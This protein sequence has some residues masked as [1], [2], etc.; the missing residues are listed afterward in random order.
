MQSL[1]DAAIYEHEIEKFQLIETH[2]SWVLLTGRYAYK[3]KKPVDLGFVDFSSLDSRRFYCNEELRLNRRLAAQQYV[4]VVSITGTPQDPVLNGSSSAF[5]YAVKMVQFPQDAQLDRVLARGALKVS[6]IDELA[7]KIAAFHAH[8]ERASSAGPY[9]RPDSLQALVMA[10]FDRVLKEQPHDKQRILALR[11][12]A[13]NEFT[14][15]HDVLAAR[16][17]HGFIRECHGDLHLRN[18]AL[19]N[20]ELVLFDCIEFNEELRW[21]DV[22]SEVAFVVM[23]LDDRGQDALAHRFLNAYLEHTGDYA[24]LVLLPYYLTYRAMVRAMVEC[25]RAGQSELSQV[26]RQDLL[27]EQRGYLALAEHYTHPPS[28][29]LII[30]HGLSGSGKT[31]VTQALLKQEGGIRIRS[32]VE[33]KRLYGLAPDARTQSRFGERLYTADVTRQTYERLADLAQ[34]LLASGFTVIADAAFLKKRQRDCFG[35]LADTLG[36]PFVILDCQAS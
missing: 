15:Q 6:H 35:A 11:A 33:R 20:D 13:Q 10:N 3:I 24:G 16:K 28:P 14:K 5:E 2:I 21:I 32:D 23:D 4:D 8:I 7:A 36:V 17:R 34:T 22:M 25:I 19:Q 12:W 30:T 31:T 26:Q 29:L 18:M 1:Q 27:A 9:G